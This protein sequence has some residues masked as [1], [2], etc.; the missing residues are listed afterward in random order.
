MNN[1]LALTFSK[2]LVIP[3]SFETFEMLKEAFGRD[4]MSRARAKIMMP[5]QGSQ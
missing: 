2:S 4:E 5:S 3:K 1:G